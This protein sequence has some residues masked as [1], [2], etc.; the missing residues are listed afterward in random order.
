MVLVSILIIKL[1][2]YF[3]TKH[4]MSEEFIDDILL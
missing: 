1:Y 2:G 3:V 4:L